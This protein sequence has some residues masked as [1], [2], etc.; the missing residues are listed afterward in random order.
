MEKSLFRFWLVKNKRVYDLTIMVIL[1]DFFYEKDH[2]YFWANRDGSIQMAA[3]AY[4][5]V[6]A[7]VGWKES[8][9]VDFDGCF[10]TIK[11]ID[12]KNYLRIDFPDIVKE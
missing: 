3:N 1:G 6:E 7:S 9:K 4:E 11:S 12:E 10:L 2:K 5:I 8:I